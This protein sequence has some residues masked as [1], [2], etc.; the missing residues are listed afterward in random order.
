MLGNDLVLAVE[1]RLP[2]HLALT[3]PIDAIFLRV[4]YVVV[5]LSVEQQRLGGNAAHVQARPAQ[6]LGLLDQ[7]DLQ[8]VLPGANRGRVTGW[9]TAENCNVVNRV[10]QGM[11]RSEME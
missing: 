11:L 10:C 8:P 5:D 1:H 2:V 9:P 3:E 7:R 4:L 6:L